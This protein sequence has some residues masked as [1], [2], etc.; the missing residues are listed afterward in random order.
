VDAFADITRS[1]RQLIIFR[2]EY[3]AT[4][5]SDGAKVN[6][7]HGDEECAGNKQQLCL[8][9]YTPAG[10]DATSF[11]PTLACHMADSP[12]SE[13]KPLQQCMNASG[14][15]VGIQQK[16]AADSASRALAGGSNAVLLE[17]MMAAAPLSL[18]YIT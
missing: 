7:K 9:Q 10:Q 13:V 17:Q 2:T 1:L 5:S 3:I 15:S 11:F 4:A 16:V 6:C 18:L 14:V 8:Q 12:G